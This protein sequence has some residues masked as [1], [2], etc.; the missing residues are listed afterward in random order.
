MNLGAYHKYYE[1][2]TGWRKK[3]IL[4]SILDDHSNTHQTLP[5]FHDAHPSV[6]TSG[7]TDSLD[8]SSVSAV[9]KLQ[10]VGPQTLQLH[11]QLLD[12]KILHTL[13]LHTLHLHTLHPYIIDT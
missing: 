12:N 9:S 2:M 10:Q 8:A 7:Q 6:S 4:C 3:T 1:Q 13:H 11:T 5:N